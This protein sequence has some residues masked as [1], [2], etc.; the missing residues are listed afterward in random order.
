MR[1]RKIQRSRWWHLGEL[2]EVPRFLLWR[3]LRYPCI[4]VQCTMCLVSCIFF[5]RFL[6]FS[7]HMAGY[8]L[9]RPC[10]L[11]YFFIFLIIYF[12]REGRE[13]EREG[14]KH[15][16]G[17]DTLIACLW[18]HTPYWGP[19]LQLG[20]VPW[21]G[22]KLAAFQFAGQHSIHWAVPPRAKLFFNIREMINTKFI[23]VHY[24]WVKMI[25]EASRRERE[26]AQM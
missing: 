11:N 7:Q 17:R 14:E 9:D 21:L 13:E 18:S 26:G 25:K 2:C 22:I 16:C 12:L 8:L 15:Q 20:H 4:I 24:L 5:N 23:M 6:Y 10:T 3:G 1:F 19:G